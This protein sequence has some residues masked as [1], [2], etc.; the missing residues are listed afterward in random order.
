MQIGM[1]VRYFWSVNLF[2]YPLSFSVSYGQFFLHSA[3]KEQLFL[4]GLF[5]IQKLICFAKDE[6]DGMNDKSEIRQSER[7]RERERERE[8]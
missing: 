2:F 7:E 6:R 5:I 3:Q 1:M 8:K 4:L